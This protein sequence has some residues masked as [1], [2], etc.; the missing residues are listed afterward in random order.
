MYY[1]AN[2]NMHTVCILLYMIVCIYIIYI[3]IGVNIK[4]FDVYH[5]HMCV[6]ANDVPT[7]LP[8]TVTA[9]L[10]PYPQGS[11][12][13]GPCGQARRC[14]RRRRCATSTTRRRRRRSAASWTRT[15]RVRERGVARSNEVGQGGSHEVGQGMNWMAENIRDGKRGWHLKTL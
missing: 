5:H 1:H 12:H 6:L 11:S 10:L 13:R 8:P 14:P 7:R 4:I 2:N 15:A 3:Y 9:D